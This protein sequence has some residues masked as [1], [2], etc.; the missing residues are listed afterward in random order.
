MK[1]FKKAD[2]STAKKVLFYLKPHFFF[3]ALSLL[4]ALV[5]VAT[6]LYIPIVIGEIIDLIPGKG[7]VDMY[8]LTPLFLRIVICIGL[9]ALSSFCIWMEAQCVMLLRDRAHRYS[10]G[11]GRSGALYSLCAREWFFQRAPHGAKQI[12]DVRDHQPSTI[13]WILQE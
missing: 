10:G 3:V 12:L 8:V 7:L 2:R 13:G 11:V 6:T 9:G 5:N 4:L 1:R